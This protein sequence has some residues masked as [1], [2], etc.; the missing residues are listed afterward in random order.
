L[1]DSYRK[2]ITLNGR[3]C[4]LDILDTAG[5][6]EFHSLR[7]NY[8]RQG[9]GFVIVYSVDNKNSF[10]EVNKF[11]AQILSAKELDENDLEMAVQ[12]PIIIVGN[13]CDLVKERRIS[14]QEGQELAK[15]YGGVKFI[16]ASAKTKDNVEE[17]FMDAARQVDEKVKSRKKKDCLVM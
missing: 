15:K 13:K 4:V 12:L 7:D 1:E 3:P 11:I 6:E 10:D 14:T 17:T 8:V 5:Q 9:E 16:E 2:D